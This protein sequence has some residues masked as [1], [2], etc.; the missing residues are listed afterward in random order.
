MVEY[1]ENASPNIVGL[2]VGLIT[3]PVLFCAFVGLIW[4]LSMLTAFLSQW[5]ALM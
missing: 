3:I 5:I 2:L 1:S 4:M